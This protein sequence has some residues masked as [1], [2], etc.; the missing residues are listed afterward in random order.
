MANIGLKNARYNQIDYTT[1]K[2]KTLKDTKVP[3]LGKLIDAKLSEDR[4]D[5]ALYADDEQ[6]EHDASFKKATLTATFSDVDDKV[7]AEIKGCTTSTDEL[8][9]NENDV[10]PELG[11]GHIV[12]KVVNNVKSYKVEFLP[13]IQITKITS[14]GKTK[15]ESIEY[16]TTS[17]EATVMALKADMNGMKAGDWKKVQTFKTYAEAE[18]YL[19]SLLTPAA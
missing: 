1:N 16:G 12:T 17:I 11:Y 5:V 4:N 14:D 9:E 10:A 2:Y 19:N 6:A 13:R 18:T 7:Y 15:G 8:T 3:V